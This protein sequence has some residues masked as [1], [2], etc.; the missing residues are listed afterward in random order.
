MKIGVDHIGVGVVY[1]CHDGQG[2][3]LLNKRSRNAKDEQGRWDCGGGALEHGESWEE[4]LRREVMEEYCADVKD[5]KFI[6]A[7]NVIRQNGSEKTHWIALIYSVLVDPNQVKNGEPEKHDEIGWF[8]PEDFPTPRH[9]KL[10][11][12]YKLIKKASSLK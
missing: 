1:F 8:K 11:D 10:D 6:K 4:G 3:F 7:V 2:N 5:F 9:S 12:H